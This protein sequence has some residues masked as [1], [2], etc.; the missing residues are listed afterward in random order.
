MF[1]GCHIFSLECFEETE[2]NPNFLAKIL[3][4]SVPVSRSTNLPNHI[5]SS[6][7]AG[8]NTISIRSNLRYIPSEKYMQIAVPIFAL[9]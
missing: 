1:F 2:F 4:K 5:H 3:S 7:I 6:K 9:Y 8:A